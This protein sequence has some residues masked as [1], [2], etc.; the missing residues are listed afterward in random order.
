MTKPV[1]ANISDIRVE[2]FKNSKAQWIVIKVHMHTE[3]LDSQEI[4]D[5]AYRVFN[6][7]FPNKGTSSRGST[8]S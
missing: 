8:V 7:V 6:E 4:R 5:S 1:M 3:S 2:I